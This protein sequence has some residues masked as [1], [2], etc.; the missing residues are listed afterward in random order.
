MIDRPI[1]EISVQRVLAEAGTFAGEVDLLAAGPPCQPFSKSR[2]WVSGYAPLLADA[3]AETLAELTRVWRESLPRV[4]LIESVPAF[5]SPGQSDGLDYLLHNMEQINTQHETA[6]TASWKIVQAADHGV[7]Q[8]RDRFILVASREGKPFTFP[9]PTHSDAGPEGAGSLRLA[10]R[11]A[12]DAIGE[13]EAEE[14][15]SLT[16]TG[17]WAELLPSIPEG[18]NYLHHTEKGD[19][20]AL[21]GWRLRGPRGPRGPRSSH[22]FG[23]SGTSERENVTVHPIG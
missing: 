7:P 13:M 23:S 21:F 8:L 12:W 3:R 1:R 20:L 9:A 11:T 10:H 6:Y 22:S 18:S 2:L 5:A 19:G 14:S 15:E 17:K 16:V 4:V